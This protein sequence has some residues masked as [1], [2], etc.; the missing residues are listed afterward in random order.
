MNSSPQ[1]NPNPRS[2]IGHCPSHRPQ[3]RWT[4]NSFLLAARDESKLDA[5]AKDLI[6]RTG[7]TTKWIGDLYRYIPARGS[8]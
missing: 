4:K 5:V 1:K 8:P 6:E 2:Y 7:T 3:V